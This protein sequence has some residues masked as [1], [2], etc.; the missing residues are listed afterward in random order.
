MQQQKW[1]TLLQKSV[2]SPSALLA[3]LGI[4][5]IVLSEK[6]NSTFPFRVADGFSRKIEKGNSK[7]PLLRQIL[8]LSDE[9]LEYPGYSSDPLAEHGSQ[10]VPGLLHKYNGRVLLI[11]TGACAIHCR[12]CF[13]RHFPYAD[14]AGNNWDPVLQYLE[15]DTTVSEVILS[16]GDP[17]T[18]SDDRLSGL[19][20]LLADFSPVLS[21]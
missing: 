8:P 16:G 4:E 18:V 3:D 10:P 17:L 11:V 7:D 21:N 5:G 20:K 6:A 14:A 12:Y 1:Q 19:I 13:R 9:E 15:K 2:K